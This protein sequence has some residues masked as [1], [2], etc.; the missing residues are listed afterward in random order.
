MRLLVSA[1]LAASVSFAAFAPAQACISACGGGGGGSSTS[2]S[3]TSTGGGSSSSG[4]SGDSSGS[5]ID[6]YTGQST[7]AIDVFLE[8]QHEPLL[9]ALHPSVTF[10]QA[11][12][13][14]QNESD[15]VFDF[16]DAWIASFGLNEQ[17][18]DGFSW[19][20]G[21]AFVLQDAII[22]RWGREAFD[23]ALQA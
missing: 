6:G 1:L 7:S 20:T 11:M 21:R 14:Y 22:A 10:E 19:R 2:T 17:L 9:N 12:A 5:N 8:S 15:G 18:Y 3:S 23:A 16:L 4:D 13:A